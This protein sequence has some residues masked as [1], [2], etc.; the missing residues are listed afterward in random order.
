MILDLHNHS[1]ASDD[2]FLLPRDTATWGAIGYLA[3]AGSV[4]T[5]LIYFSLL[6]TWSVTSLSFISVFT[7]AV[8]LLLGFLFLDE[9]LSTITAIGAAFILAGVTLALTE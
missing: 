9:R 4:V 2:G 6:K 8:A 7:P 5:F 3:V 1:I